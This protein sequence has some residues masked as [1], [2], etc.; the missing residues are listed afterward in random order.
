MLK[1]VI[2]LTQANKLILDQ[3]LGFKKI[4]NLFYIE[5]LNDKRTH[6]LLLTLRTYIQNCVNDTE[7][8][9]FDKNGFVNQTHS[10]LKQNIS[11]FAKFA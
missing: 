10:S 3:I 7:N 4:T 1:R 5:T 9:A 6:F 2:N 11:F 8:Y